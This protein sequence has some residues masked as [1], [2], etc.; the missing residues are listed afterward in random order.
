MICPFINDKVRTQTSAGVEEL[1][2]A[3]IY[4]YCFGNNRSDV[5]IRMHEN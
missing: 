5:N 1:I 3:Y 4:M 2:L